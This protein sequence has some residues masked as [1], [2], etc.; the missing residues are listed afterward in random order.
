M[1]VAGGRGSMGPLFPRANGSSRVF[2]VG[3]GSRT[4]YFL[5]HLHIDFVVWF[6]SGPRLFQYNSMHMGCT[7]LFCHPKIA[8]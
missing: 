3:R 6:R 7:P 1:A 2:L 8:T 4:K 5:S